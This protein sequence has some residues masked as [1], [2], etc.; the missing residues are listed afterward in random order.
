MYDEA[1][2]I[3]HQFQTHFAQKKNQ[4]LIL[5]GIGKNTGKLLPKIAD[6]NIAGLMD[7]KRKEG[8]IWGKK[9]LDCDNVKELG[10]KDIIII[11]R[12]AVIGVIY[13]RIS[14]FCKNN[15]I[16]VWD[17]N[18][19][20][21]SQI[22]INQENDIPYF[23][24]CFEN[25]ETEIEKHS[26]ISFDIFD[27]LIMRKT[28]YPKDIF[29]IIEK[30]IG[31]DNN[32]S[33]AALRISAEEELNKERVNPTIFEI[34]ERLQALSGISNIEKEQ[35]LNLEIETELEF[36]VPR[37]R[38]L[39]LFEHIKEDK[40]IYLISDMYF[41]KDILMKI[42][43]KCGYE[44]YRDI[45][46]SCEERCSKTEGLFDIF[47]KKVNNSQHCLHIGD[48]YMADIM[49]AMHAGLD[50]FQVM[51]AQE[52]LESSSYKKLLLSDMG[53]MDR[54]ATGLFC[55]KGFND[56]F[57]LSGTKGKMCVDDVE[58][59]SYL[60]IAPMI[61]YFSVWLFQ[62]I[63]RLHC[64]L[65]LYS[66]RDSF[67][68]RKICRMI[69]EKQQISGYPEDIY[70]YTSRRSILAATTWNEKDIRDRACFDFWGNV[71]E[72]FRRRF[73][74]EIEEQGRDVR[75][76][77]ESEINILIKKY[78]KRILEQCKRERE[79]YVSYILKTGISGHKKIALTDFVAVGTVQNGLEKLIPNKEV[80]GF[81]FLKRQPGKNELDRDVKAES[82][83]PSKGDFE[84]DSNVY[85]YYLFLELV[86]TSQE[87]TVHSFNDDGSVRFMEETRSEVHR[88][89]VNQMQDSILNYVT[90]FVSLYPKI[91]AADMNREVP[92][93]ILGFL[94]KE[95]T[96]LNM[97]EITSLSL[98]D[99]FFSQTFNILG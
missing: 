7:G 94:G 74:I 23:H 11:A 68:I 4:P 50:A 62:R 5:Y 35:I 52:L 9:I 29:H 79:N 57:A 85:H 3:Y 6:Y 44:G 76:M 75:T 58:K 82:F 45:Y 19:R 13:H 78:E 32:F 80:Q 93:I 61:F 67:L 30:K 26:I 81:Y 40:R 83:Y 41:T 54:L 1:E 73:D 55:E 25:L 53:L 77:D 12:P 98:T 51:S 84:I 48:N 39:E 21:L 8:S 63:G 65:I 10:V 38:M 60:F 89:I 37:K 69:K 56:P 96:A 42:L 24:M 71:E 66:S 28:L 95:Y 64:D 90:E 88:N 22:Y 14:E 43:K 49:S 18:G 16:T 86:L 99:E 27:T 91:E 92:D 59:F 97:E 20:D 36:L 46:V 33:F 15:Q 70:F 34:Y 31:K 17:V 72:L 2:Y 87:A 47:R